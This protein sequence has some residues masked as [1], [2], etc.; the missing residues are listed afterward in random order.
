[1][2]KKAFFTG[3]VVVVAALVKYIWFWPISFNTKIKGW[4]VC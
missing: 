1:M 4:D 3:T 2:F